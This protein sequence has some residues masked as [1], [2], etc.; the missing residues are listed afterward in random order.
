MSP[1]S[2]TDAAPTPGLVANVGRYAG[3]MTGTEHILA[4]VLAEVVGVE[5]VL[6]DSHFFADLGADSLV[7][8]RFCARV[9]KRADLPSVSIKDVYQHPTVRSLAAALLNAA[10]A[11]VESTEQILA[12]TLAN[13][14]G[15]ERVS[16]DSN[17]FDDLGADSLLMARFCSRARKRPGLPPVSMKDVYRHPTIR[18]LATA[19]A[20]T[21]P[22]PVARP[23]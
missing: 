13:I 22:A 2:Q 9:R 1:L 11:R 20:D 15:A 4:E 8:A 21:A 17:F 3:P 6:V 7:M 10:P 14:L 5:R 23:V 18:S 19:L 16:V 12:E